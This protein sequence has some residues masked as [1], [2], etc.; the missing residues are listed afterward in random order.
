[1][2][3]C[4]AEP[5]K[6]AGSSASATSG[7]E[8]GVSASEEQSAKDAGIDPSRL[9]DPVATARIPATA[10]DQQQLSA[11][12]TMTVDF[13]GLD[14]RGQTL[15]ATFA[16][17]PHSDSKEQFPLYGWLGHTAWAPYLI[18]SINLNKHL[19]LRDGDDEVK[20][21]TGPASKGIGAEQTLYAYAVFSAPPEG[22]KTMDV[23]YVDGAPLA[24][25]VPI[26]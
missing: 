23:A 5:G 14:R 25:D 12:S 16:F 7:S 1:M 22:V 3:A 19:V 8:G 17:T 2:A 4:T 6:P 26:R 11:P 9:G 15:V 21:G 18:D 24:T 13:F 10:K 20:T